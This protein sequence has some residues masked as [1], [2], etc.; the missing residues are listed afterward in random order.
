MYFTRFS[1]YFKRIVR[2]E[3]ECFLALRLKV[4]WMFEDLKH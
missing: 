1:C 4:L 2:P 3:V